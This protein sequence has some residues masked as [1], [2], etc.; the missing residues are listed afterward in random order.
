[1]SGSGHLKI[2]VGQAEDPGSSPPRPRITAPGIPA[3]ADDRGMPH[4]G[5]RRQ[6]NEGGPFE[7]PSVRV[8]KL[9]QLGDQLLAQNRGIR[10]ENPRRSDL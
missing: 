9:L 2:I 5:G 10:Q 7:R 1:M 8:R 6:R 3:H 4:G